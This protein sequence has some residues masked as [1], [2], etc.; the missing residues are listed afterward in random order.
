MLHDLLGVTAG[1]RYSSGRNTH[2]NHLPVKCVKIPAVKKVYS[3]EETRLLIPTRHK[4]ISCPSA[5]HIVRNSKTVL[6]V[7]HFK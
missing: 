5:K 1:V 2:R 3:S 4:R 6:R 7:F